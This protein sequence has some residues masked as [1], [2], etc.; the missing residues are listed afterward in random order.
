[1]KEKYMNLIVR[2]S[3]KEDQMFLNNVRSI[4]I[5]YSIFG[6]RKSRI[7]DFIEEV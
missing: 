6:I 1:M 2:M 3:R 5:H 7:M 4:R